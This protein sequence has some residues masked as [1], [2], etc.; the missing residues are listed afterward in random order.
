MNEEQC[1]KYPHRHV[2]KMKVAPANHQLCNSENY[3]AVINTAW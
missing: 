2:G 3:A 1:T